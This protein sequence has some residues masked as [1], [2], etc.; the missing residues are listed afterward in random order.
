MID[1]L[2]TAIK[3]DATA[4]ISLDNAGTINGI[5][6][7]N[8]VDG[9]DTIVNNGKINGDV[10]LGSGDDTF[11]GAGGTSGKVFGEDGDDTITGGFAD[12]VLDG[13]AGNDIIAGGLGSDELWGGADRDLFDFNSIKDSVK[14]AK[15][16]VINDFE[17]GSNV[18]GD[19]IDLRDIDA[20]SGVKG[21]QAFKFIGKQ[22]FHHVKGELHIK[23]LGAS[24]L[25]QGDVNGN[26][27]A[28]FEILVKVGALGAGDFL[29]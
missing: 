2:V 1:G 18:T 17:R 24:C 10:F 15:H 19:A 27:K 16:D 12:D 11:N 5:I 7:L 4:T 3:T 13:G 28:D 9:K 26:G 22:G 14:G 29:L 25:V 6:D 21:N 23:H 20:K 8:A